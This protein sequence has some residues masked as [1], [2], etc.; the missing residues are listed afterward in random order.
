[1]FLTINAVFFIE[2]YNEQ[3]YKKAGIDAVFVQDNLSYSHKGVLRGLHYQYPHSQAKLVFVIAGKILD[4]AL[5]IRL[6]SKTFG[7]HYSVILSSENKKQF[8]IPKGF[9][10]GFCALSDEVIFSYKCDDFYFP[11]ADKGILW[12]DPSLKIDWQIKN[13]IVSNKDKKFK[14]LKNIKK[15]DLPTL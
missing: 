15:E 11:E 4:I 6:G 1:M 5:D 8:Y 14:L 10:H 2:S 7:K 3:R 13:P 12:S 9:A